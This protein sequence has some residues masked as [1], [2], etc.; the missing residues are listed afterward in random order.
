MPNPAKAKAKLVLQNARAHWAAV[1]NTVNA[2]MLAISTPEPGAAGIVISKQIHN[3]IHASW[4]TPKMLSSRPRTT[5]SNW[6]HGRPWE[7]AGQGNRS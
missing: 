3:D 5:I 7:K 4:S 2:A 1:A 6:T